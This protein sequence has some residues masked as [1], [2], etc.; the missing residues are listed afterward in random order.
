[1]HGEY[2]WHEH[3]TACSPVL[4]VSICADVWMQ[5]HLHCA[6]IHVNRCRIVLQ[7]IFRAV[8]NHKGHMAWHEHASDTDCSRAFFEVYAQN[9]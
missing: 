1:M 6:Y 2:T 4:V 3:C 7:A 9:R 8:A 5:V